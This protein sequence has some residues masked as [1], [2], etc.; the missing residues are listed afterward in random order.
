MEYCQLKNSKPQNNEI[1]VVKNSYFGEVSVMHDLY[2]IYT[3]LSK[4]G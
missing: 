4:S 2:E 3:F 1:K